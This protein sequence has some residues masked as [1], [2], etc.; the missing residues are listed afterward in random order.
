MV[1]IVEFIVKEFAE[2]K[3]E[4]EIIE[5][6][7][8]DVETT[9]TVRLADSDMGK[10]IG[11]QGKLA[12]ALRTIVKSLAQKEGKK[13]TI[14]IREKGANAWLLFNRRNT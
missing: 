5:T 10:V 12:K 4:V 14:E 9:I 3:D 11:K 7:I 1:K 13:Y 6:P 2:K 8:S